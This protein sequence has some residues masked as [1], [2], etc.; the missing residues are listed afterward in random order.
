MD[1]R[2]VFEIN[3]SAEQY[4]EAIVQAL[5]D[6]H[7]EDSYSNSQESDANFNRDDD[8]IQAYIA[9]LTAYFNNIFSIEK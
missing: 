6:N 1:D 4:N 9:D 5:D 8:P 2:Y 7:I 3:V